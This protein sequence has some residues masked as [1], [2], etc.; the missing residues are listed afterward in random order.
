MKT[1][2]FMLC[3]VVACSSVG[4]AQAEVAVVNAE[5]PVT[6]LLDVV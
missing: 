1:E 5:V 6:S 4:M 2:N 3:F